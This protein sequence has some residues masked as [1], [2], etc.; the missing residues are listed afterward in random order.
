MRLI[1]AI[2]TLVVIVNICKIAESK[3]TI[4]QIKNTLKPYK[5]KCLRVTGADPELV[6]GTKTGAWPKDRTL[7]CF[8]KCIY[9]MMK[10]IKNDDI[11]LKA[12][13][14]QI[15]LMVPDEY[16]AQMKEIV[17]KCLEMANSKAT[18]LCDKTW[19]LSKCFYEADSS[20]RIELYSGNVYAL[21]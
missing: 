15:D 10:V 11:S 6:E 14:S 20:V 16:V 1:H 3:M 7:M 4:E 21:K 8:T 12:V 2:I 18:D 5:S 13:F 9:N 17:E 19:L